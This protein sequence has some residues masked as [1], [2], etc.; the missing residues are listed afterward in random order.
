MSK[1]QIKSHHSAGNIPW[2][3]EDAAWYED[4]SVKVWFRDGSVKIID[5]KPII[6]KEKVGF[7]FKPLQDINYFSQASYNEES[8]T[9]CWP[10]GADIAPEYLYENGVDCRI[11]KGKKRA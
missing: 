5:L 10:N 2:I 8:E 9:I 7:M 1:N 11:H 6:F 4:Y 3:V